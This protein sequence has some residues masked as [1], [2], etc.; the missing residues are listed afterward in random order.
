LALVWLSTLAVDSPVWHVELGLFTIGIGV[1]IFASPNTSA[2]MGSVDKRKLG[3][4]SGTLATMRCS[5]QA[6]S[7]AVM[8]AIIATVAG[9]GSISGLFSGD[10]TSVI[11][12]AGEFVDG[13]DLAFLICSIISVAGGITSLA[14]GKA[15]TNLACENPN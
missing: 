2:V 1:G 5:G 13:M 7:L 4:A 10:P 6:T 3:I 11:V 14:R 15:V 9:A 8:G 12:G